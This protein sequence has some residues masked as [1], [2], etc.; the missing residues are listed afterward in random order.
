MRR[1]SRWVL[2]AI[3]IVL[4]LP[5]VASLSL[6]IKSYW[7]GNGVG[8]M[9]YIYGSPETV[10]REI[11]DVQFISGSLVVGSERLVITGAS[12]V[13]ATRTLPKGLYAYSIQPRYTFLNWTP[14]QTSFNRLGFFRLTDHSGRPGS[15]FVRLVMP[16]WLPALA[17]G[18]VGGPV[19][20]YSWRARRRWRR[21]SRGECVN[22]GYD[23]HATPE[24]CPEC[25]TA[26]AKFENSN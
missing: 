6:W 26:V 8:H 1:R 9:R 21:R 20:V 10:R 22:C 23:C 16:G 14:L 7:K 12:E 19:A 15:T 17:L 5:S 25:G 13:D 11:Y 18:A 3:V 24:R 2:Y 4:L